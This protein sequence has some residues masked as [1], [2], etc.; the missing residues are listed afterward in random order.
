MFF[1]LTDGFTNIGALIDKPVKTKAKKTTEKLVSIL[2]NTS[3]AADGSLKLQSGVS[4]DIE[5]LNLDNWKLN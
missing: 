3:R 1:V 2:N 4:S 5:P